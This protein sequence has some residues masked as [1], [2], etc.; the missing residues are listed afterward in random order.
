MAVSKSAGRSVAI[1]VIAAFL[2]GLIV[3][4]GVMYGV[5][6][7]LLGTKPT[8]P[9]IQ[10]T[11]SIPSAAPIEI[12]LAGI[13]PLTGLYALDGQ[14][15]QMGAQL[16]VNEINAQGG[17]RALGGARLNLRVVDCGS[18][19]DS[20]VAA[21]Q[22]LLSQYNIS[23]CAECSY[24]SSLTFAEIPIAMKNHVPW[25]T[26]SLADTIT[27]QQNPWVFDT[28]PLGSTMAIV[29]YN[30][31]MQLAKQL[32][33]TP[34]VGI[35]ASSDPTAQVQLQTLLSIAKNNSMPVV[36]Q[37]TTAPGITDAT[38]IAL[39][40]K[41]AEVNVLFSTVSS[42]NEIILIINTLAQ[43]GVKLGLFTA[44]GDSLLIPA[45]GQ[46][47]GVKANGL[48]AVVYNW[49]NTFNINAANRI[50]KALNITFAHSLTLNGYSSV[51]LLKAAMEYAH[52]AKGDAI[53]DALATMTVT[54]EVGALYPTSTHTLHFVPQGPGM[55][56]RLQGGTAL[57]AQWQNGIPVCIYPSEFATAKLITASFGG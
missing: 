31:A 37:D 28:S 19:V 24:S 3:G 49:A 45:I 33:I 38:T 8:V 44:A 2:I 52:S 36:Y 51:Y 48:T 9:V 15:V 25:I 47:L 11:T 46:A 26:V 21:T 53:R 17:I 13:Y 30:Y 6:P 10:T 50:T 23:A 16:A 27:S 32:G 40:I 22:R 1:P 56:Y 29:D 57:M 35:I 34:R 14:L 20:A 4:A 54:G 55:G 39:Q 43:Q 18:T 42:A 5:A 7:S 41:A 12:N